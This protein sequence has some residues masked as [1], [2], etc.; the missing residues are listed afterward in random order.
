EATPMRPSTSRVVKKNGS[1]KAGLTKPSTNTNAESK[2]EI[3]CINPPSV[4]AVLPTRRHL[5][6]Q[7]R[8]QARCTDA[9][10]SNAQNPKK[11]I[12]NDVQG[13][14]AQ[15]ASIGQR[16]GQNLFT[17]RRGAS[18][19]SAPSEASKY[20]NQQQDMCRMPRSA[21]ERWHARRNFTVQH[22]VMTSSEKWRAL[23]KTSKNSFGVSF[24]LLPFT[25][26]IT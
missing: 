15:V 19:D 22:R 14:R 10:C 23:K 7:L 8:A 20:P 6:R 26:G 2:R 16:A 25:P 18:E 5:R 3:S 24:N 13:D 9:A 4:K 21:N 17:S 12:S 11:A 1:A